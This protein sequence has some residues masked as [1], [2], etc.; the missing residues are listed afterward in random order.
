MGLGCVDAITIGFV[1]PAEIDDAMAK[2]AAVR[3]A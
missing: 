1:K 3:V 2:I